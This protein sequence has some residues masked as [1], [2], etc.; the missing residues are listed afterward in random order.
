[1]DSLISFHTIGLIFSFLAAVALGASSFLKKKDNMIVLQ[2][3][4]NALNASANFFLGSYTGVLTNCMSI[5]RNTLILRKK[6]NVYWMSALIAINI[7]IGLVINNRGPIGILALAATTQYTS[8]LLFMKSAQGVRVALII[9]MILWCIYDICIGSYPMA[10]MDAVIVVTT[11][12]N[13]YRFRSL[14]G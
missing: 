9:N 10:V 12:V 8:F 3:T 7:F 6:Y 1:M 4:Y 2:A 13:V 5:F 11:C 14:K